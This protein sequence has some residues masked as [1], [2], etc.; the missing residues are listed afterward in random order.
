MVGRASPA[1]QLQ[2]LLGM[3]AFVPQGT[4]Y[5]LARRPSLP[6]PFHHAALTHQTG[7]LAVGPRTDHLKFGDGVVR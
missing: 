7:E 3:L 6:L 5:Q 2:K 1:Q 4:S